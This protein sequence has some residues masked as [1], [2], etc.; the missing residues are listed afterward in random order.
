MRCTG[1]GCPAQSPYGAVAAGLVRQLNVAWASGGLRAAGRVGLVGW[2]AMDKSDPRS[3][4]QTRP[5][6]W[7]SD[8]RS[9]V[10]P[11]VHGG[12]GR[13]RDVTSLEDAGPS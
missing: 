6:P 5:G 2:A 8:R 11:G 13:I 7:G 1:S 10:W 9:R 3:A 4:S 12:G